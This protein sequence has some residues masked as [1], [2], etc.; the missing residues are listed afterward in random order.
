VLDRFD[1]LI[2]ASVSAY[3]VLTLVLGF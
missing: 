2:F 1:A 3:F